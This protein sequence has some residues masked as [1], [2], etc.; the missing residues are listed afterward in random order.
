MKIAL[1][2]LV[3]CNDILTRSRRPISIAA[4]SQNAKN[5]FLYSERLRCSG[6]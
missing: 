1:A 3:F 2:G 6:V 5:A 4:N